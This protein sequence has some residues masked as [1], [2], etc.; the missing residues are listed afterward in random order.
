LTGASRCGT[1]A[2][3]WTGAATRTGAGA[4]TDLGTLATGALDTSLRGGF[5]A[6]GAG[7]GAA[8]GLE[9]PVACAGAGGGAST[10]TSI[11][12][13]LPRRSGIAALTDATGRLACVCAPELLPLPVERPIAKKHANTAAMSATAA[14]PRRPK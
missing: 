12:A 11:G 2:G 5:A 9:L 4:V 6:A 10:L 14:N 1:G 13:A 7:A 8:W 3:V